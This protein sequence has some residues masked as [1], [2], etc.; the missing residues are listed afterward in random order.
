M[1]DYIDRDRVIELFFPVDPENDGS[2][3][4]TTVCREQNF[5][6]T[7]IKILLSEFPAADVAPMRRGQWINVDERLP[8]TDGRATHDYDV[9]CYVP[10]RDGCH[11]NGCYLGKLTPVK[12][13]DGNKNFW[14]LRTEA[15]EWTLWGW[16]YFEHPVVTHWMPLPE[17]PGED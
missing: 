3:G 13:D 5:S 7:E 16:S 15:S 2:D 9:L 14:G 8:Q 17:P 1:P 12:A 4:C 11:Q 10:K 6:S